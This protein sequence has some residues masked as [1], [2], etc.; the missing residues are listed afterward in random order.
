MRKR[1]VMRAWNH[2]ATARRRGLSRV[3]RPGRRHVSARRPARV[4]HAIPR[5]LA[6]HPAE[7]CASARCSP[8]HHATTAK[9]ARAAKAA[10]RT[11][12]RKRR[13]V[14]VS[15]PASREETSWRYARIGNPAA[16]RHASR[17][18]RVPPT[19]PPAHCAVTLP[20]RRAGTAQPPPT[21]PAIGCHGGCLANR[22]ARLWAPHHSAGQSRARSAYNSGECAAAVGPAIQTAAPPQEGPRRSHPARRSASPRVVCCSRHPQRQPP[23]RPPPPLQPRPGPTGAARSNQLAGVPPRG[24]WSGG[25]ACATSHLS[26]HP[27]PPN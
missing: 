8:R 9:P 13:P 22:C 26:A 25:A 23:T 3:P 20:A 21:P 17:P 1:F 2:P 12:P 11:R 7:S 18:R 6:P 24:V 16:P 27:A 10:P 4:P 19:F 5:P 14:N 15:L